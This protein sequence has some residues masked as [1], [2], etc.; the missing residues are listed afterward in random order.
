MKRIV[1]FIGILFCCSLMMGQQATSKNN[2]ATN[3]NKRV[4]FGA[5]AGPTV[6]WFAPSSDGLTKVKAK[7]GFITG[8]NVDANL[9]HGKYFYF[10]TGVLFRYLQGDLAFNYNHQFFNVVPVERTYQTMYLT[11]PTG[12]TFRISATKECIIIG[13]LGLYHNFKVGGNRFDNFNYPGEDPEKPYFFVTT[14][15]EKNN[16]AALFAESAYTGLGFEYLFKNDLRI[17]STLNYSCQ[18]NYF[19]SNAISNVK[20]AAKFKTMIHSLHVVFGL[21][22]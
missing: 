3:N 18:L 4:L 14:A 13:K 17:F 9:T 2:N 10:S 16:H 5:S 11:I 1:F 6:D 15:K 22:F 8:I 20:N 7:A 21:M 12:V 19:N